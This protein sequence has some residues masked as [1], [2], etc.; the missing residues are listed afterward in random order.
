MP[1]RLVTSGVPAE[2]RKS[3]RALLSASSIRSLAVADV[4]T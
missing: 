3:P 2:R 1:T 4:S